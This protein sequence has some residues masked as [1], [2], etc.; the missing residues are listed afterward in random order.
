MEDPLQIENFIEAYPPLDEN[1]GYEIFRRK[2]FLDYKMDLV[3][4]ISGEPG[5]PLLSQRISSTFFSPH[6]PYTKCLFFHEPGTGK[7]CLSSFIVENFKDIMVNGRKRNPALIISPNVTLINNY[8]KDVSQRCTNDTYK[9][10]FTDEEVRQIVNMGEPITL[11]D[12]TQRNRLSKSIRQTYELVTHETFF[13]N[14]MDDDRIDKKFIETKYSN[15]IIVI[16]EVHH[17]RMQTESGEGKKKKK[18]VQDYLKNRE[19]GISP[20]KYTNL[21]NFLHNVKNCR[22]ILLTGTPIWDSADEIASIMNLILEPSE[23]LPTGNEFIKQYFVEGSLSPKGEEKLRKLFYG[24]VS[25]LRSMSKTAK[26]MDMGI[27][28]PPLQKIKVCPSVMSEFQTKIYEKAENEIVVTQK[29]AK[30]KTGDMVEK[31]R[32]IKGG[33]MDRLPKDASIFVFPKFNEKEEIVGGT[34]GDSGFQENI[35]TNIQEPLLGKKQKTVTYSYKNNLVRSYI[36]NHLSEISSKFSYIIQEIKKY[37]NEL[38]FIYNESVQQCGGVINLALVLQEHGFIWAKSSKGIQT[39]S[40]TKRFCIMTHKD[41]AIHLPNEIKKFLD[42]FNEPDNRYGDRCQ[43]IIGSKKIS[44]GITIKNIRQGH[45]ISPHWNSSSLIQAL[46]RIFRVGSHDAFEKEEEKYVRIYKHASVKK[47]EDI[48]VD[49]LTFSKDK[50][51]DL[52]VYARAEKKDLQNA[53]I[54]RILKEVSWDCPLT[55]KRNV[56]PQ[57]EDYSYEADYTTKNYKCQNFPEEYIDTSGAIWDYTVPEKEV[58][59]NTFDMFYN[60]KGEES[61]TEEIK[62]LFQYRSFY[63]LEEFY[64]LLG[65]TKDQEFLLLQTLD[66]I[67]NRRK[68]IKNRYGIGYFLNEDKDYYYLD[69]AIHFVGEKYNSFYAAVPY[70]YEITTAETLSNIYQYTSDERNMKLLCDEP[71]EANVKKLNHRTSIIILEYICEL[72]HAAVPLSPKQK[73]VIDVVMKVLGHN[74]ITVDGDKRIHAMYY[75]EYMGLGYNVSLKEIVPSGKTRLFHVGTRKWEY[76]TDPE[77][78]EEYIKLFKTKEKKKGEDE[79]EIFEKGIY[80]F[81]DKTDQKF[82]IKIKPGPGEK[83]TRGFVCTESRMT[84]LKIYKILYDLNILPEPYPDYLKLDRSKLL[85]TIKGQIELNIFF[86]SLKDR[87]DKELRSI[88]TLY[89]MDKKQ[90]CA[91]MEDAFKRNGM[92]KAV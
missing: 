24:K 78:E 57:I 39:K 89:S 64:S 56:I 17:F 13:K 11:P 40:N 80:G 67:I 60:Q 51:Y 9:W 29:I 75:M 88:L 48:S 32:E 3:E 82:K 15:R 33:A 50:T 59:R 77:E 69:D 91:F 62:K 54:Y 43:I 70:I 83:P 21:K 4:L 6:T 47:G 81:V 2:E 72:S 19:P 16:D 58:I 14:L 52:K 22:I 23:Q 26:K 76:V 45:V 28:I 86:E 53:Q 35:R 12:T 49:G 42:S 30:N 79:W 66:N 5:I 44:E 8:E 7:S 10:E 84:K 41:G 90:I 92:F 61:L 36:R 46:G 34:Y 74:L 87:T 85:Q 38:V 25:F 73:K 71:T 63:F 37:P 31:R 68:K 27:I 55:Y 65:I 20:E 1:L 18:T